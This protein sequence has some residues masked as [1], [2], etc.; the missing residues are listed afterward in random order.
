[1][2][3]GGEGEGQG[4][5]GAQGAL[6]EASEVPPGGT[7]C[8]LTPLTAAVNRGTQRG[9]M[10]GHEM[11]LSL[12]SWLVGNDSWRTPSDFFGTLYSAWLLM[13]PFIPSR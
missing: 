5:R 1:M 3:C 2:M 9:Q 11:F 4:P 12:V 8:Y 10:A 7:L 6:Q 13:L